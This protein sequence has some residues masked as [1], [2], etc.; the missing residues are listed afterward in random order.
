MANFGSG[1]VKPTVYYWSQ[2]AN[3]FHG[4]ADRWMDGWMD[5]LREELIDA[6]S[7]NPFKHEF[8]L[9][10][11]ENSALQNKSVNAIF[12]KNHSLF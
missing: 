4:W 6:L 11:L 7:L 12:E 5:R 8:L 1:G 9:K 10:T 2:S 3:C